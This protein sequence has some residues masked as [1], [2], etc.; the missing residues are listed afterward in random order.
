MAPAEAR[1]IFEFNLGRS[2]SPLLMRAAK[3]ASWFPTLR[4]AEDSNL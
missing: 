2:L 3:M 4:F 1:G